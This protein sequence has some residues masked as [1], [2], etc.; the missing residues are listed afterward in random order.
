MSHFL[1]H[2]PSPPFS[3]STVKYCFIYII[4]E[5]ILNSSLG[6]LFACV[7]A[8]QQL[9]KFGSGQGSGLVKC[10]NIEGLA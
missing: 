5:E 6:I 1:L 10:I 3:V 8:D 2:F 7:I 9:L 4:V